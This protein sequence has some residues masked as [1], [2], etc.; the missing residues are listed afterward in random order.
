M[1]LQQLTV[2]ENKSFNVILARLRLTANI[3]NPASILQNIVFLKI[4][5]I[6]LKCV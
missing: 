2:V 1:L 6:Y 5:I 4:F 3:L